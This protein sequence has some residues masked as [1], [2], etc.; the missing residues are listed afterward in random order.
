MHLHV[1]RTRL[2]S[3]RRPPGSAQEGTAKWQARWRIFSEQG[4]FLG[5][6]LNARGSSA[7]ASLRPAILPIRHACECFA[8]RPDIAD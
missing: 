6:A 1:L 5:R 3:A 2:M 7:T 8:A 4:S